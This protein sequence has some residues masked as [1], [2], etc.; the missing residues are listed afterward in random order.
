MTDEEKTRLIQSEIDYRAPM[1][2]ASF[3][4]AKITTALIGSFAC[5]GMLLSM[6]TLLKNNDDRLKALSSILW[7]G[8]SF[9]RIANAKRNAQSRLI[10]ESLL[11]NEETELE[12]EKTFQLVKNAGISVI[13]GV[14]AGFSIFIPIVA[15]GMG[16]INP[17]TAS[18]ACAGIWLAK[19]FYI[20]SYWR[21]N[22]LILKNELPKG[23]LL[24]DLAKKK[25]KE[26]Y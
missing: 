8:W 3:K 20:R 9:L 26:R 25:Q 6:D 4:T 21:Q 18:A 5:L 22:N 23:V 2:K 19:E 11:A 7:L 1:A 13:S 14:A 17:G 24:P 16:R 15:C 12:P 10:H